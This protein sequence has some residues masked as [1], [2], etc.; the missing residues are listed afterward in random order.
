M[1]VEKLD[2][3]DRPDIC[4]TLY[5]SNKLSVWQTLCVYDT[6]VACSMYDWLD[7][8][9]K[10]YVCNI[11]DVYKILKPYGT[12]D[13]CCTLYVCDLLKVDGRI[14]TFDIN[15]NFDKLEIYKSLDKFNIHI[16]RQNMCFCRYARK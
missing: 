6:F 10:T 4:D 7:V 3:H 5:G 9:Y 8:C 13:S 16:M 11:L 12:L 2:I 14:Y 15:D 1:F